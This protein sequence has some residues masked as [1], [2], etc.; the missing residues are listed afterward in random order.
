MDTV[1]R[2]R[3]AQSVGDHR[4][5]Q[6]A[7][8][9]PAQG[10]YGTDVDGYRRSHR[11]RECSRSGGGGGGLQ[12]R[13][14]HGP[15]AWSPTARPSW[16][17]RPSWPPGCGSSAPATAAR[18]TRPTP[19]PSLWSRCAPRTWSRSAPTTSW[20]RCGCWSTDATNW[21]A[22]APRPSTGSTAC[23][24]SWSPAAQTVP[25][26]PRQGHPGWVTIA[27]GDV[28]SQ[29]RHQSPQRSRGPV[30][31]RKIK[32]STRAAPA[33]PP[34]HQPATPHG[35]APPERPHP[36]RRVTSPA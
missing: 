13:R 34:R 28:A 19:T 16:T 24:S 7:R 4:G 20:W 18:A 2:R 9:R 3:P 29:V 23:C 22:P 32:D 17:C 25:V 8:T 35:T 1:N 15:S 31:E 11:A 26:A 5:S 10:R 12:R 33:S 14:K 21:P 30:L 6:R 36:R 27:D